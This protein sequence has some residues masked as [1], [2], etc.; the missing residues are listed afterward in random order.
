M[1]SAVYSVLD[2]SA[3][4]S[5]TSRLQPEIQG[6]DAGPLERL[7]DVIRNYDASGGNWRFKS[8]RP[9]QNIALI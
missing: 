8:S 5:S 1:G 4:E 2:H 7:Y 6:D 3:S 9:D